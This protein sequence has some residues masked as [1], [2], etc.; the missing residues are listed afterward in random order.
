MKKPVF[1]ILVLCF[2]FSA[3]SRMTKEDYIVS[4]KHFVQNAEAQSKSYAEEDWLKSDKKFNRYLA[5]LEKRYGKKLTNEEQIV[6][7]VYRLRYD[8]AHYKDAVKGGIEAYIEN[9]LKA[10]VDFLIQQGGKISDIISE[11]LEENLR[12]ENAE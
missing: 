12:D 7:A 5:V 6:I 1:F 10:D 3:C 11:S 4:F 9:G 8:A 2:A